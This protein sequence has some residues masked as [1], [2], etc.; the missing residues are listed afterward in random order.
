MLENFFDGS[1]NFILLQA[2]KINEVIEY[3]LELDADLSKRNSVSLYSFDNPKSN[4]KKYI[5][6]SLLKSKE[7]IKHTVEY[8]RNLENE[9]LYKSSDQIYCSRHL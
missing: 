5:E 2:R 3:H 1:C 8:N 9:K 6:I 4:I 7:E